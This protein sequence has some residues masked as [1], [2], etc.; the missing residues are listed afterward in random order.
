MKVKLNNVRI[1]FPKLFKPEQV[2]GEGEPQFSATFILAKDHPCIKDIGNA[3]AQVAKEKWADKADAVLKK[4]KAELKVC[5]KDGD[6]KS[7]LEGFENKYYLN[8][9]NKTRPYVVDRDKTQLNPD[10]GVIYAGC[11]VNAVVDIWA[12]DNKFGKRICA[13]LSGVQFYKDGDAFSGGG[14]ASDTDFDDL[15]TTDVDDLLA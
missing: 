13:S 2:N 9:N 15:T 11:Y 10:D 6:I 4:L 12:M 1:A 7:E 5:L 3:I 8:A 14:V